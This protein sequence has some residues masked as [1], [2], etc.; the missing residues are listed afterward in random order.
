MRRLL[1]W[2]KLP[3]HWLLP[4][5][6]FC[7][8][9]TYLYASPHFESPDSIYHVGFIK[10]IADHGGA[11]PVQS[12]DHDELFAHEGSQPPLYYLLM[13]PIW[14]AIDT[15][16]FV[17]F[18]QR[19]P[20]VIAGHPARL[21]NRN[22]V[23][24]RQPHPP[25]LEGTSLALTIIRLLTLSMSAVTVYAVYKSARTIQ[26][27]SAGFALLATALAAFNPQF[28]F[29]SSSISND[30]LVTML[31]SLITWQTLLML[32]DGFE[33]RRSLLISLLI[34]L[35]SLSKLSGLAPILAVGAAAFFTARRKGDRRGFVVL[36]LSMLLFW[37][38]IASWWYLRNVMLYGELFGTNA[39]IDHYG[40]RNSSLLQLLTDESEGFRYSYW[41]LFGW[42][43]I[44]TSP[45]HYQAM[46][47]L[48]IVAVVG[49]VIHLLR[50]RR[51]RFALGAFMTL[52]LLVALG[53][54]SLIWYSLQ[55]TASQG[56]LLFPT[57]A[58]ISLLLAL[59][60]CAIRLP[61]PLIALLM[62][63]FSIAAPILYIIPQYDHP[64][65]VEGLPAS[66]HRVDVHWGEIRLIGYELPPPRR[67][68]PGDEIPLTLYWQP[69][70]QSSEPHAL[71]ITLL[72]SS[73]GALAT[74]DSFPGWGSL[75]T[76]WW[77]PSAI[78]KDDYI[79]QI[80]A[81]AEGA[82][83]VRLHIGWHAF[84]KGADIRPI[85]E[86]GEQV[87]AYI[88]P[89]GAFID[90]EAP[91][92]LGAEARRA[93]AVFGDAIRLAA[94]RFSDGHILEL[95]W[96]LR[97]EIAGDLRVFAIALAEP[98]QPNAPFEIVAQADGNPP[99]RLD[100]FK[101]GENFITR[102]EFQLPPGYTKEH[103]IYIGWY[104]ESLGQRLAIA[105][106]ENMLELPGLRFAAPAQRDDA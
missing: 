1:S 21:G 46:D 73:G 41:G 55:T 3:L 5:A 99:A 76:T 4:L 38:V 34:A 90:A 37:L 10:W 28:L 11:L 47:S 25:N 82:S 92:S 39:L 79:L 22:Q 70:A 106:P 35:A 53:G 13:T 57:I 9:L 61:A 58:A 105:H 20:L 52:S 77:R 29:V 33:T 103:S 17:D 56:R 43:S 18:F 83:A 102:H 15:A 66:A 27:R 8:G 93:D 2:Q 14:Q 85:L 64:P 23:F 68:S 49:L 96:Q 87:K 74:I 97:R 65:Q 91:V 62:L 7:V 104:D 88:I 84:P 45:L 30:N 50:I 89:I 19:N 6:F 80:P 24:Y 26:P 71:F 67:W 16:D 54:A 95:E 36:A 101:A 51:D 42:F 63:A 69:S 75:P 32:R 59:G 86:S 81:A 12:P 98:Y 100:F 40:G 60:I 44:F 48:S 31:V 94:W 72:D 78:Y